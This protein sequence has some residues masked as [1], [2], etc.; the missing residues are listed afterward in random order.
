MKLCSEARSKKRTFPRK[1]AYIEVLGVE[2][3]DNPAK[4]S[5]ELKFKVTFNCKIKPQEG[6][7]EMMAI[8]VYVCVLFSLDSCRFFEV[9]K[10]LTS[11]QFFY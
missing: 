9:Y 11:I 8:L 4:F 3:M 6:M 2:V 7:Q 1:M 5:D 10:L